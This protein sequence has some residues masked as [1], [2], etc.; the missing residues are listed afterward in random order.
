LGEA[1]LKMLAESATDP[2]PICMEGAY[3]VLINGALKERHT[4]LD[5]AR[6]AATTIGRREATQ[7]STTLRVSVE[8]S[9]CEEVYAVVVINNCEDWLSRGSADR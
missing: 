6:K 4:S 9:H 7:R 1:A 2:S 3:R 5:N 8:T